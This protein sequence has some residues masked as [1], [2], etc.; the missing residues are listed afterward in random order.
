MKIAICE[1]QAVQVNLLNNKI[2]K[3]AN[4]YD[5]EVTINNFTTAESFLFE[6]EDYDKYD[7]IFLDIKLGKI[8]GVE[9][10]NIIREKNKNVD[11]VFV[12]GFFKYALHGYKVGA[13][14]YLMKPIKISD[15]Y[16]CLNKTQE[17]ISNKNDKYMM[18][19][20][21]PKK[22]IKLNCNEI[23][24]CIMFSPYID[25]HTSSEKITVRKKIS[26]LE[27]EI[28]SKYFIRCHRSYIVN[29]KYVKSITKDSVVLESGIRIPISR[30]RYKDINDTFI[31]YICE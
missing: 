30:G 17:R 3:W 29:L 25:I 11:I 4:D 21:T 5:I 13:L 16:F 1:D 8:S 20:E 9:L 14:Q 6:W 12:T 28:P 15:L 27:R 23:H 10:S 2:K 26:E 7:I 24:Y 19:L 18:I 22:Y 31:N